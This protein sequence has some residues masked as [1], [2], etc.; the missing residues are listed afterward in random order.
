M[1]TLSVVI[2]T[3]NE[4][5]NIRRCLESV[6]WADEIILIDSDSTDRTVEIA[7][8]YKAKVLS[9]KWSGFGLAK[10][11]GV[12]QATKKW[13]LSIDADEVLTPELAEEIKK[14]VSSDNQN[15]GYYMPRKTNF[16]GRWIKHCGW[17]PDL[18][19]RLF[20]K[21]KG[22]FDGATVH[23]RVVLEGQS[24]VLKSDLLHYS[25]PSLEHYLKKYNL[26]TTLG[27]QK[28][29]KEGRRIS[30][31][32]IVLRPAA[33]FFKHYLSRSGFRDGVEG[34]VLSVLSSTAVMVKYAKL[35]EL[36]RKETNGQ[37]H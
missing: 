11:F 13:I 3:K 27:A 19:L 28:A 12:D 15:N 18:L 5:A 1:S 2:I 37:D 32:D 17:Y 24:G 36:Q 26:Y 20:L 7:N 35:R 21:S 23:E 33:A 22:R 4:E 16:M 29:A 25:N 31:K 34:F 30:L 14:V 10:Q 6:K 9:I 8:E